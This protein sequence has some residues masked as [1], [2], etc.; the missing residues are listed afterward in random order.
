MSSQART[1]VQKL[2]DR[3]DGRVRTS[4]RTQSRDFILSELTTGQRL[5]PILVMIPCLA[6]KPLRAPLFSVL[7]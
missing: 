3:E 4:T 6:L 5:A 2:E 1:Q 7:T